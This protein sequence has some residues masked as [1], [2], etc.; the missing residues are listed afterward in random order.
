MQ[1]VIN[2]ASPGTMISILFA[3]AID[4]LYPEREKIIMSRYSVNA[5]PMLHAEK[6]IITVSPALLFHTQTV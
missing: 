4:A 6:R 5:R 2:D 1:E 3:R